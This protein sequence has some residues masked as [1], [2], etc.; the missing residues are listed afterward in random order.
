M[1][2]LGYSPENIY[3]CNVRKKTNYENDQRIHIVDRISCRRTKN[4]VRHKVFA[5]IWFGFA[6]LTCVWTWSQKHSWLFA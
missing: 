3:F 4:I 2:F 1:R 5:H 6:M